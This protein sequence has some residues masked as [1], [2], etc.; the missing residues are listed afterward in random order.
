VAAARLPAHLVGAREGW[1]ALQGARSPAKEPATPWTC[2]VGGGR[3]RVGRGPIWEQLEALFQ[4]TSMC[5]A[6]CLLHL[7]VHAI[8]L[9]RWCRT[10]L[11]HASRDWGCER[12]H[13]ESNSKETSWVEWCMLRAAQVPRGAMAAA[14][15]TGTQPAR[16]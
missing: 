7:L 9:D 12:H 4:F 11:L 5:D 14:A 10:L 16:R 2:Q 1:A 3:R 6:T 13:M 15:T 8:C